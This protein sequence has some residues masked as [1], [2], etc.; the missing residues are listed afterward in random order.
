ML[1]PF[2]FF[3]L[4]PLRVCIFHIYFSSRHVLCVFFMQ[5]CF[6]PVDI[7]HNQCSFRFFNPRELQ[8]LWQKPTIQRYYWLHIVMKYSEVDSAMPCHHTGY[9]KLDTDASMKERQQRKQKKKLQKAKKT[10]QR[11]KYKIQVEEK[12]VLPSLRCGRH[13]KRTS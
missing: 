13:S 1:I 11:E 12:S 5:P 10:N 7:Q 9:G 8:L 4:S 2:C 3:F 6:L